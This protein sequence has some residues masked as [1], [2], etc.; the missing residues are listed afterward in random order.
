MPNGKDGTNNSTGRCEL[1]FEVL[2]ENYCDVDSHLLQID[3]PNVGIKRKNWN[4]L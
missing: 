2:I 3:P 4:W 1:D